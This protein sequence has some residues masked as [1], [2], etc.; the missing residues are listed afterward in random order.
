MAVRRVEA[1]ESPED[2]VRALGFHRSCIYEW[3]AKYREGGIEGLRTKPIPG[4]PRK[5]NGRQLQRV[6]ELVTRKNP[7]QLQFEFALWTRQMVRELIRREFAVRL[8]E[9]SVG[10]L[11]RKLG[12]SPQRPLHRAYQQDPQAVELW[13][14]EE[15][16]EVQKLARKVGAEVYFGDEASVRSDYHKGTTWAPRGETPVVKTTGARFSV[17]MISAISRRGKLRFMIVD[18]RLTADRFIEFLKRL[19][20]RAER[21]IF[22]VVDRH[23][24]HRAAKVRKFVES[25]TGAL[26]LFFLPSY[27]PELNPDELVW[28]HVKR[29]QLGKKVITGPDQLKKAVL[30]ALHRLQ[31]LPSLVRGFFHDKHLAY[32]LTASQ[33]S[34]V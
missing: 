25:T 7:L 32:A 24:V 11:L 20:H 29:H 6:Y 10:R 9:V 8:S 27:S 23:P 19:L 13:M 18:G 5:L 4:R 1:G 3:I 28:N 33:L 31:K 22:L 26:Q 14:R 21:P 34:G 15:Y 2:V 30:S 17:N 16:P 12:L